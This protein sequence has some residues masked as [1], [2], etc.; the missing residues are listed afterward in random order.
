MATQETHT[1]TLTEMH[2]TDDQ[3]GRRLILQANDQGVLEKDQATSLLKLECAATALLARI[4]RHSVCYQE[5]PGAPRFRYYVF[6]EIVGGVTKIKLEK[7]LPEEP[8]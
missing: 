3:T 7:I 5:Q 1:F 8:C 6:E 2:I 4:A